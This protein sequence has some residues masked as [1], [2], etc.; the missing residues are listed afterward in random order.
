MERWCSVIANGIAACVCSARGYS[1]FHLSK[2]VGSPKSYLSAFKLVWGGG[3]IPT[4]YDCNVQFT[5]YK[6]LLL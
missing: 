2:S 3:V 6:G 5:V 1:H 4:S